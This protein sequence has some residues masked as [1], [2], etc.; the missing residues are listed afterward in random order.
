MAAWRVT[1][2]PGRSVGVPS[3][4][5]VLVVAGALVV[6]CSSDRDPVFPA[7][8]LEDCRG[9]L[10]ELARFKQTFSPTGWL[11]ES[12]SN[13]LAIE[14]ETLYLVYSFAGPS[15]ELPA[16][17]GIVAVPVGGGPPRMVVVAENTASWAI[18]SFWVS[19][20]QVHLQT[21]SEIRVVPADSAAPSPVPFTP[22]PAQ[23]AAYTRDAELAYSAQGDVTG[24][25][26]VTKT[27]VAGGAP[28]VLVDEPLPNLVLG[29]M[30]EAGDAVLLQLR[31]HAEPTSSGQT[32]T[33]VWRIPKDGSGHS[34][35]RPDVDWADPLSSFHWLGWDG[36]DVIGPIE[37]ENAAVV[38]R[39][40][41]T[42]MSPPE[43]V[44]LDGVIA[45]RRGDE[46]LSLQRL[47][48]APPSRAAIDCWWPAARSRRSGV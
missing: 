21:G 20:G 13:T 25:L 10:V 1:R 42:G 12:S 26:T 11:A 7:F 18:P 37:V 15:S 2:S 6:S 5:C 27:P 33:R 46:I 32:S 38:A 43:Y 36:Q 4:A 8:V 34:D 28:V 44:K 16:S 48:P 30:A 14:G 19:G 45:T 22:P 35:V 41:P 24:R 29:G 23:W 39:V 3:L 17:G 9:E 47:R 40:P 31:W